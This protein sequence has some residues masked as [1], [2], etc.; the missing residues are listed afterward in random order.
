[1][2]GKAEHFIN[3]TVD[4][5]VLAGILDDQWP[6]MGEDPARHAVLKRDGDLAQFAPVLARRGLEAKLAAFGIVE[7]DRCDFALGQLTCDIDERVQQLGQIQR[8]GKC[9][10]DLKE[11]L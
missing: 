2:G 11:S 4:A 1:V 9:A 3:M 5:G 10:A 8:G 6:R 7:Q